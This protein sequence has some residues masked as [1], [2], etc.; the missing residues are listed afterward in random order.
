MLLDLYSS[1][2]SQDDPFWAGSGQARKIGLYPKKGCKSAR[3]LRPQL[4]QYEKKDENGVIVKDEQGN[5]EFDVWTSFKIEAIFNVSDLVA[6]DSEAQNKLDQLLAERRGTKVVRDLQEIIPA[7]ESCCRTWAREVQTTFKGDRA[8]YNAGGD[9]IV[10]PEREAF[11]DLPAFYAT[12]LHEA[13][14]STGH[15]KRLKRPFGAVKHCAAYARE[16][17][18]AELAS[19][20][21][22]SRLGIGCDLP[23]HVSYLH[24]WAKDLKEGGPKALLKAITDARCAADLVMGLTSAE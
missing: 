19:V 23:N 6:K 17:L 7:A 13:A 18:V 20:L 5:V 11:E 21:M 14:H 10:M 9:F 1:M 3:I 12:W 2:R 16:E 4:N 8:Y 15:E 22:G 24:H